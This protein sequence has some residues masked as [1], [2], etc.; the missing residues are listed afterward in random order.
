MLQ[1]GI[2]NFLVVAANNLSSRSAL[3]DSSHVTPAP[4]SGW[5]TVKPDWPPQCVCFAQFFSGRLVSPM[6]KTNVK[7][8]K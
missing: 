3:M 6:L 8:N 2:F 1:I 7:N 4:D 5:P